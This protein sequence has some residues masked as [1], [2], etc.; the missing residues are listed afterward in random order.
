M[1]ESIPATWVDLCRSV[2]DHIPGKSDAV[3]LEDSS[4]KS[5]PACLEHLFANIDYFMKFAG[6]RAPY[7]TQLVL[8]LCGVGGPFHSDQNNQLCSKLAQ[9]ALANHLRDFDL[10]TTD[11]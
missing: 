10:S 6:I 1:D 9:S 4:A 2:L 7:L 3:D 5:L 8:D 11:I